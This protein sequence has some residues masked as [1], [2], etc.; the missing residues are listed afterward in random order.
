MVPDMGRL[1]DSPPED[2]AFPRLMTGAHPRLAGSYGQEVADW[3]VLNPDL[4]LKRLEGLRW[5]QRLALDRA[6]EHDAAG[7]LLWQ[8]VIL[9][10]P[11]QTGKSYLERIVCAWRISQA[12]RFGQPQDVLHVAHKLVAAQEVWRPAA[13]WALRR[14]GKG[15]VRLSN[16][17]QQ[18][19]LPDASRWMVQ[20]ATDGAGVAFS[21]S[22]VLVDEAWRIARHVVD[23]ALLPTMAEAEQPQL[24]LVSTAGTSQSDLMLAYRAVALALDHPRARDS[25]LLL[26]WSAPPDP[27]LDITDPAVW[28]ACQPFW[29][30]RRA[31]RMAKAHSDTSE[32]MFRQQWLNQWVP[33]ITAPLFTPEQWEQLAWV[34]NV[35]D[36]PLALGVDVANDRSHATIVAITNGVAEVVDHRPGAAWVPERIQDLVA[37]W[38]PVAIGLDGTGPAS[39]VADQLADDDEC[40]RLLVT[41]TGR[42]LATACG[43][44][45]DAITDGTLAARH[46]EHLT[47]AVVT[48]RQRPYGQAWVF[49][50]TGGE[51][52]GVPIIALAAAYWAA[53]HA[54]EVVEESRI[55]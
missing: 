27:D 44:V 16:G 6:L 10:A 2:S 49:Q 51:A 39:T 40:G 26:E 18:I 38:H 20:A 53:E 34:G 19:E 29:D 55:W 30:D 17:E 37:R 5:W 48:A 43:L 28:R 33:T 45:F 12:E 7:K 8:T 15:A 42:H 3:A 9:S 13:R 52:S 32:T 21:L 41:M 24:W 31:D 25:T 54:P 50:R 14:H 46:S 22:M 4:H 35:P 36:G 23:G 47:A 11:R 1:F